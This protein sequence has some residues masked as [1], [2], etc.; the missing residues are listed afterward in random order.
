MG[1][2]STSN[3]VLNCV[4]CVLKHCV[5]SM[6]NK[7]QDNL[8][9]HLPL[10]APAFVSAEYEHLSR[11]PSSGWQTRKYQIKVQV[12]TLLSLTFK[13]GY[14]CWELPAALWLYP[15]KQFCRVLD[16]SAGQG[17]RLFWVLLLHERSYLSTGWLVTQGHLQHLH[18]QWSTFCKLLVA[19]TGGGVLEIA[20]QEMLEE[21]EHFSTG[22]PINHIFSCYLGTAI[23]WWLQYLQTYVRC[24]VLFLP[25]SCL[26]ASFLIPLGHSHSWPIDH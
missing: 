15:W 2:T 18:H 14:S 26:R 17:G 23:S 6:K 21:G 8:C 24:Q 25:P 11:A 19:G 1:P 10:P 3:C 9:T 20:I 12:P 7:L 13:D 5:F 16:V 22:F 4:N